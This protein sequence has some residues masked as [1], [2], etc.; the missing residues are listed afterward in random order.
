MRCDSRGQLRNSVELT[1]LAQ[2]A[3]QQHGE[4]QIQR[5]VAQQQVAPRGAAV[6]TRVAPGGCAGK[7]EGKVTPWRVTGKVTP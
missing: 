1:A 7:K 2:R 6:D 3:Q 4:L 5:S